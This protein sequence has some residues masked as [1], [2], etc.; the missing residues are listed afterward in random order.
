[1]LHNVRFHMRRALSFSIAFAALSV[2]II[3]S[4]AASPVSDAPAQ[5]VAEHMWVLESADQ[6][7]AAAPPDDAATAQEVAQL[8]EMASARDADALNQIAYWNSGPPVYR[9]NQIALDEMLKRGVPAPVAYRHLALLHVAIHDA[10]V[11]TL[12]SKA[13]YNRLRPS[14]FDTGLTTVIANPT[15]SSYPS[16]YAATAGA[17]STIMGWLFPD[18]AQVFEEQAQQA[19]HSRLLAGVEYPSDADAGLLLGQLVADQVIARGEADGFNTPS[20]GTVPT[21]PGH[22]TG[23]NPALPAAASWQPWALESPDQFRPA[24]PAAY[25][26]EE[27]AA[28]MDELYA[29][30]R[31]PVSNAIA[32]F[33]EYGA[34][35]RHVHWYWNDM[36]NQL[37]LAARWEDQPLLAARAYALMN[38]A[39]YD[40]GIGCWD[41][42]YTYWAM[43]PAQVDPEFKP[44]FNAPGHP[45][46]PS[47]HSCFS[48]A[49]A[50]VLAELFPAD[51]ERLMTIVNEVGEA[52]IWAGIHFRSD[53][54]AGQAIGQNV[55]NAVMARALSNGAQ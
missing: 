13:T 15:S 11:A 33:W 17:A 24:P 51:T 31:T 50:S 20:T 34:G 27:L 54:E 45:S 39:G 43:R 55:A 23:E 38:I 29:F 3:S 14:Q 16:D 30:E 1:M 46:Y 25:D 44:L 47:A 22:W 49:S 7:R 52:R 19:V 48:M 12:D 37:V 40:S 4:V 6:F 21:E 5:A 10:T 53:I 42:K 2:G 26:S 32:M 28:E 41:A 8:L 36:A 9:W 35:G 18:S